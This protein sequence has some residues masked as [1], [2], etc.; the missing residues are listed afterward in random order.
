MHG[1]CSQLHLPV[2][3]LH[4]PGEHSRTRSPGTPA[5]VPLVLVEGRAASGGQPAVAPRA[6]YV[7]SSKRVIALH[8]VEVGSWTRQVSKRED[9]W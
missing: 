9:A 7:L 3:R 5:Q 1:V 6:L 4:T 8:T 2:G